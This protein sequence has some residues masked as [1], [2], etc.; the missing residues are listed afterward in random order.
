M[1]PEGLGDAGAEAI[2]LNQCTNKGA[3]VV[4]SGAVDQV[5]ERLGAGLTG[6][7]FKVDQMKL[8]GEIG[9]GVIQV[10]AHAHQGLVERESGLDAY[11]GEV[12][13]VGQAEANAM[14]PAFDSAL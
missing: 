2:S 9:M 10:L 1:H 4:N 14:L 12:K 13:G 5:A 8:V 3:D 6:S 11:D 7:H